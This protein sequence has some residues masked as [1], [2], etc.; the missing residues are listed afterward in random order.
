MISSRDNIPKEVLIYLDKKEI[1]YTWDKEGKA[2]KIIKYLI[3]LILDTF[4]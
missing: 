3:V 4:R 1:N 2:V